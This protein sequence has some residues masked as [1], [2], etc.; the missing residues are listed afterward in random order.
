MLLPGKIHFLEKTTKFA[1]SK[2]KCHNLPDI[3]DMHSNVRKGKP[4]NKQDRGKT[5]TL[6][7][8]GEKT[9]RRSENGGL[10]HCTGFCGRGVEAIQRSTD[11]R[12][13]LVQTVSIIQTVSMTLAEG[14]LE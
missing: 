11:Y 4:T 5:I 14:W 7:S 8:L 2:E 1:S 12:L 6:D 3:G 13:Y 10:L 9:Q